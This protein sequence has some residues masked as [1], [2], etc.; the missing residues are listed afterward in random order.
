[1]RYL[2][3]FLCACALGVMPL[4]GCSET[5]GDGGSGGD[6]GSGGTAGDGGSGGT[7]GIDVPL[8]P[9]LQP[10][11]EAYA[12]P[13]A[14]VTSEIMAAVADEIADAAREIEDSEIFAE[15]LKVITDIQQELE[16]A[17]ARTCR[18]G[19]NNGNVCTDDADCPGGTCGSDLVFGGVCSGGTNDG[20]DCADDTDCPGDPDAGIDP[21]TC[22]VRINYICPGWDEE[23]FDPDYL[24]TCNGGANAGSTCTD[25]TDCPDGTCV[26][27][28]PDSANGSIDL[29]MTVDGGGIGRV[30]W[31]TADQCLYLVPKEGNDCEA[32]G[33]FEASYDGGIA[34]DLGPDWVSEDIS[35]L[36]VTFVVEGTIGFDGDAFR[37]DQSFRVVLAVE[38]GLELLLDIGYPA[39]SETFNYIFAGTGQAIRDATGLFGCS[40]EQSQCFN[41]ICDG[42]ANAGNACITDADCPEGTCD[43]VTRFSW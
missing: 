34:L 39:L 8:A 35:E 36:P 22:A 23:Q 25:D 43:D 5:T 26:E 31:G 32:A 2:V 12:N 37:I 13:T 3:G 15:I 21:G 10:V 42:G 11:L 4:V 17:T 40:L 28:T 16:N 6:A 30:V 7:A 38:P 29:F 24:K 33:C 19:S 27:A 41:L 9:D 14:V 18:G 20:G 1:M